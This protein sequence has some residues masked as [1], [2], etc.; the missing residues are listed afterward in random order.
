MASD[1]ELAAVFTE[2]A[3]AYPNYELPK[4]SMG[5]Y[6]REWQKLDGRCLMMAARFHIRQSRFFPA[7]SE[8]WTVATDLYKKSQ[9]ANRDEDALAKIRKAKKEALPRGE[10]RKMLQAVNDAVEKPMPNAI[11]PFKKKGNASRQQGDYEVG[12]DLTDEQW[13]ERKRAMKKAAE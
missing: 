8:L 11:V 6:I 2:L 10:I 1:D 13:E 9:I 5:I 12:S 4:E 7:I 3:R